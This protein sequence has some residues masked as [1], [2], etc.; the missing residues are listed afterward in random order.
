MFIRQNTFLVSMPLP[1]RHLPFLIPHGQNINKQ[2]KKTEAA[3][4][5]TFVFHH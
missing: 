5:L 1:P 2:K 3:P 4:D